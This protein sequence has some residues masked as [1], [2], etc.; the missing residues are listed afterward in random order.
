MVFDGL[1][2]G[3]VPR[4]RGCMPLDKKSSKDRVLVLRDPESF[5]H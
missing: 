2:G 1:S 3:L 4:V 5:E